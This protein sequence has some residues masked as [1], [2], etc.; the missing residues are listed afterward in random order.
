MSSL[1]SVSQKCHYALRA[2]LEL[3]LNYPSSTVLTVPEIA[4]TQK[5]P[6]RFLEQILAKL[7]TGGYIT[8]KRGKQ[9]GYVLARAPSGISVGEIIRFIEGA[10]E[11]IDCLK[12]DTNNHCPLQ[13]NCV[14]KDLWHQAKSAIDEI[15]DS[16]TFQ[17]LLDKHRKNDGQI[18]Y[19]I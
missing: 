1:L 9:G 5:I 3:S 18:N 17:D 19:T 14:F 7:R 16:T 15:F 4:E 2:L 12:K 11:S 6:Y 8:S 13:K 10:D